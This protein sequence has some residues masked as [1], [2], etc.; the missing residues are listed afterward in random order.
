MAVRLRPRRIMHDPFARPRPVRLEEPPGLEMAA[1]LPRVNRTLSFSRNG[2]C[3]S[4]GEEPEERSG[5][6]PDADGSEP[7]RA[8][9]EATDVRR[10]QGE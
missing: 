1:F 9:K 7:A 5:V 2:R 6:M 10:P 4:E 3:I 8:G